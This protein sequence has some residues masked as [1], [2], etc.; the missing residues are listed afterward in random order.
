MKK[1]VR[2]VAQKIDGSYHLAVT[3]GGKKNEDYPQVL[4]A[5]AQ[6]LM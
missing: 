3:G 1:K 2:R 5:K 6:R 4:A